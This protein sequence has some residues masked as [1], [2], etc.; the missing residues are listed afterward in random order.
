MASR[1]S[2]A[3][4]T[5]TLRSLASR[6]TVSATRTSHKTVA[7]ITIAGTTR[8]YFRINTQLLRR[9]YSRNSH[10]AGGIL[11]YRG[12]PLQQLPRDEKLLKDEQPGFT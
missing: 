3:V 2:M 1:I 9:D 11:M 8:F 10:T 6:M 4:D 7:M 12:L 5:P